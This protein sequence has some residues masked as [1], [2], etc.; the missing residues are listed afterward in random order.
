MNH[1]IVRNPCIPVRKEAAEQSEMVSQ[2]LFGELYSLIESAGDWLYIRNDFDAYEGWISASSAHP[3]DEEQY[4]HY[5]GMECCVQPEA[6]QKLQKK[7]GE[8]PMLVPAGSQLYYEQNQRLKVHCVDTWRM[9]KSCQPPAGTLPDSMIRTGKKFL[10]IPYLWGGK[11]TFGTDCSGLVQTVFRIHGI[12]ISRDTG[13]QVHEGKALN[14]LAEAR[15]GDLL[16]FDN[17]E[18]EI[19]H[20]GMLMEEGYILHASG[21]VRLDPVD[22]QG[23][24]S[25]EKKR[26]THKLR[27]IKRILENRPT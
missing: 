25:R 11:S 20:V 2:L 23:I 19:I 16:F 3:L 1:G 5:R 9:E 8:Q 7:P 27:V 18:G 13:S 10:H 12:R 21:M 14:M 26:Y 17:E 4:R 15:T 24:Y 22:H 6:F